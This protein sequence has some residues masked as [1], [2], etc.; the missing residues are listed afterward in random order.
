MLDKRFVICYLIDMNINSAIRQCYELLTKHGLD[1]WS[2]SI[3][4]SRR[5]LGQCSYRFKEIRLSQHH[6]DLG[7]DEEVMNTIRHEIA[8]ALVG[9]GHGHNHLWREMACKLGLEN[10]R[11]KTKVSYSNHKYEIA[12]RLCNRTVQRR[13]NRMNPV[14]MARCF[15]VNCGKQSTGQLY[16]KAV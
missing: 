7:T 12:C 9:P 16:Q 13:M 15:C 5:M 6:I 3:T 10:P 1:E 4:R 11:S 2:V 8:H 14:R